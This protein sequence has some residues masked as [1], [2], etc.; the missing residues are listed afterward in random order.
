MTQVAIVILEQHSVP[1]ARRIMTALPGAR[2]YGLANRTTDVDVPFANLGDT[3]HSL[4]TGGTPIVGICAAEIL[5]HRLAP[6]LSDQGHE[7]PVLVVAEDGHTVVPLLGGFHGAN[8]LARQIAVVL[9]GAP[10]TSI[11]ARTTPTKDNT[12]GIASDLWVGYT[13]Y[14]NLAEPL[15]QGQR[16]H[17]FDNREE[18]ERAAIALDLAAEG[19]AVALVS[20]GDPGI[21][22]MAAAVFEVLEREGKPSWQQIDIRVCP[23]ISAMQA[24]AAQ[25]GA[26]LGHDFCV[27]SLS[28]I[29]KPWSVIAQRLAAAAQADLVLVIYNPVSKQRIWQLQQAKDIV[30][31]WRS[32]TTPVII[33]RNLGRPGQAVTVKPLDQLTAGDADM[34]TIL[35]IGSQQTRT[36]QRG[37]GQLWVYTPRRYAETGNTAEALT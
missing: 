22:A 26:P 14:L 33:A 20:S 24:A 3:L 27:I 29:L 2:L 8:H 30:L 25:V 28:D 12:N 4:F 23:G 1:L 5:I 9:Q 36:I 13:T 34:R 6:L 10:L 21:Y 11:P 37:D 16:R 31:R 18:I 35:L 19:R 15:R 17:E 32:P 7:T